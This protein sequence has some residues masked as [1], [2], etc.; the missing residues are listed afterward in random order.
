[1]R[2]PG[3]D[4]NALHLINGDI[5]AA[6]FK[7]AIANTARLIIGRDVLSIGPTPAFVGMEAW[8]R[9]RV[10]FWRG[11]LGALPDIDYRLRATDLAQN[12][13]RLGA[14]GKVYVWA[15]TG[16][17]D[18]LMVTFLF[19]ILEHIGADPGKVQLIEFTRTLPGNR[20][21]L[22]LGAL[23]P[24]QM[25]LHPPPREL[26][27]D[28][29]MAFRQAWRAMSSGDPHKVEQ[30]GAENPR[31]SEWLRAAVAQLL[32]RYPDRA[33]G[34]DAWDRQLLA[35]VRARG[36]HAGRV[37]GHTLGETQEVGDLVSDMYLFTRLL[38]MASPAWPKPL[39]ITTGEPP[40]MQDT[41][42]ELTGFGAQVLDGKASSWP[43]NPIDDWA[44][45]VHLSSAAGNV[46]FVEGGRVIRP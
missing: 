5:A 2:V 10:E 42:V 9:M 33:S 35:N 17:T 36:P 25:R 43:V 38:R 37:I 12:V 1:M 11:M 26:Q 8:I 44:G 40:T 39:L 34:L 28:E 30:F 29:W 15:G 45:G 16:N 22:A 19:E 32:R 41:H 24:M 31:A 7:Q 4:P 14:A 18:Q 27:V 6:T 21:V 23:D 20:R 3:L 46:W 13:E